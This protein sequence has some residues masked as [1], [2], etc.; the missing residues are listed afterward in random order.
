ML[1]NVDHTLGGDVLHVNAL[2]AHALNNNLNDARYVAVVH[3]QNYL[4]VAI[5]AKKSIRKR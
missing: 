4:V 1:A 2:L 3:A 5:Q